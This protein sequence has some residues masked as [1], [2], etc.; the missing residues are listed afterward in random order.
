M[1]NGNSNN[2]KRGGSAVVLVFA[3]MALITACE[4]DN[5]AS[6]SLIA[7]DTAA[8]VTEQRL[9]IFSL[10]NQTREGVGEI[11]L[12]LDPDLN[13][14]A[15]AHARDMAARNFFDHT[16][17]DGLS[18]FDRLS[19]AGIEYRSA[20][21]NIAWYPSAESAVQGWINSSGHYENLIRSSFGHI[22]IGVY[23]ENPDGPGNF[24]YVQIFTD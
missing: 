24:Y 6:F 10:T 13:L 16:N 18:P 1:V 14:V 4:K 11:P 2:Q 15:Q 23:K 17:P 5:P 9:D 19:A 3:L 7:D 22:G 20:G 12:V 21:E 8:Y